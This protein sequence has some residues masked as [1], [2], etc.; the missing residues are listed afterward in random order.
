MRVLPP[1]G[2][3]CALTA[4][5]FFSF[6]L[7]LESKRDAFSPVLLQFC[8]DSKNPVTVIRGLAGSLRLSKIY[9]LKSHSRPSF[10]VNATPIAM[11]MMLAYKRVWEELLSKGF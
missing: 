7:Q 8:T 2:R 5:S 10:L 6:F 11:C 3:K 1:C 4:A 9:L